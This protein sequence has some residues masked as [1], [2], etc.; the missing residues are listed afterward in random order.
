MCS[1]RTLAPCRQR[2]PPPPLPCMFGTQE[3][4]P[5]LLPG[6]QVRQCPLSPRFSMGLS[7]LREGRRQCALPGPLPLSGRGVRHVPCRACPVLR[8]DSLLCSPGVRSCLAAV[9]C[10]LV[11]G[12]ESRHDRSAS[13]R[14]SGPR[15]RKD[16]PCRSLTEG[17][18]ALARRHKGC[19]FDG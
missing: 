9:S 15:G 6:D 19:P 12:P 2:G 14:G 10:P 5:Y 3:R 18:P 7:Q 11:R 4:Q 1:A 17:C 16:Q 13:S 8:R